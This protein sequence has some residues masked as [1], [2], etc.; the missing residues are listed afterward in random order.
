MEKREP[1]S[2][3][4]LR[5]PGSLPPATASLLKLLEA[6]ACL[7]CGSAVPPSGHRV[8]CSNCVISLSS[9]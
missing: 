7:G 9:L 6:L 8:H 1:S 5:A 4:S 3:E 2:G